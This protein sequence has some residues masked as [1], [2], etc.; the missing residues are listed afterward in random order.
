MKLTIKSE[1]DAWAALKRATSGAPFPEDTEIV[2]DG[3][4]SYRFDVRGKDWHS[5]V[6][7]RIMSPLLDVQKDINRAYTGVRYSDDNL[8]KLT[9]DERDELEVVVKV[10]KGSSIFEADLWKQFSQIAEVAVGRMNGNQLVITVLGLAIAIVAPIMFK[11]W[12]ASRQQEK[13]IDNRVKLSAQETERMKVFAAAVAAKPQLG[14]TRD[15][16]QSTTNRLLKTLKPGDEMEVGDTKI[17]SHEAEAVVQTEREQSQA[18]ELEGEFK[19]ISNHTEK[20]DGFRITVKRLTDSL[21]INA[22][23]PMELPVDQKKLI[24]SAEWSKGVIKLWIDASMLRGGFSAATVIK[25]EEV[26]PEQAEDEG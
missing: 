15:S 12:L 5:S 2:F 14:S 3:W 4:P 13:E 1:N 26:H 17:K 25:A 24:Q 16:F 7:T 11:A 19:V 18:I 20:G 9:S 8:R 23:V 22:D 6:P 10:E 21:R